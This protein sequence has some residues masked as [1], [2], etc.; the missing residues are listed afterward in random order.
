[1]PKNAN[2]WSVVTMLLLSAIRFMTSRRYRAPECL[3]TDGFYTFKMDVWSVGCVMFE[4]LRYCVPY[5]GTLYKH[6]LVESVIRTNDVLTRDARTCTCNVTLCK[7]QFVAYILYSPD[8]TK[9]TRSQRSM[10][11]WALLIRRWSAS[12]AST[13]ALVSHT[14]SL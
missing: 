4:I 3:L 1:M 12:S 9:S 5:M 7:N 2:I 14:A 6:L 13:H 10:T 8:Q 11:S